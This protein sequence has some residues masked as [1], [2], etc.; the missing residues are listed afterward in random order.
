MVRGKRKSLFIVAA[1]LLG[2]FSVGFIWF[3]NGSTTPIATGPAPRPAPVDSQ[4]IAGESFESKVVHLNLNST[5]MC[6]KWGVVAPGDSKSASEA[7]RRQTRLQDWCLVVVFAKMVPSASYDPGWYEGRGNKAVVY[8]THDE[9]KTLD[10]LAVFKSIPWSYLNRKMVGYLYAIAHGA[11]VIWDF[12]DKNMLKFWIPDAAPT[13]APSLVSTVAMG[14][15]LTVQEVIGHSWPT[16]N[17][18]PAFLPPVAPSWPRGLPLDDALK[19]ECSKG[20]L[21]ETQVKSSLLAVIHSLCDRIPDADVI[22]QSTM[23]FPFYFKRTTETRPLLVPPQTL[24][25]YNA[26]AT[27]HLQPAFWAMYLPQSID[28]ELSDI[29][30]SYIAQRLF[31]ETDLRVGFTARPLVVQDHDIRFTKELTPA[32]LKASNKTKKLIMFL[33]SWKADGDTVVERIENLWSNLY[34]RNFIDH[35]DVETLH[36]WLQGLKRIKYRFPELKNQTISPPVYPT[37]STTV[38]NVPSYPSDDIVRYTA[39]RNELEDSNEVCHTSGTSL[40]FWNSDTHYGTRLDMSSYLGSLGHTVYEAVGTRQNYHPSVWKMQGIHLYDRVSNI[41]KIYYPDWTGMNSRLNEKMIKK[42]FAFYKADPTIQSVDAFYCLFPAALCEMWMPFN[43]S[44]IVMPAHRYSI[45]RCTKPEFDRL[46][47]HLRLLSS[48]EHPKHIMAAASKYDMEYLRHYTGIRDVLP[49]YAHSATIIPNN[50][51]YN[52]TRDEIIMFLCSWNPGFFWDERFVTEIKK[53]K[54]ID[55][56]KLYSNFLFSNFVQHRAAVFLPYAVMSYKITELYVLGIPLF[57]PSMKYLRNIKPIGDDRTILAQYYCAH[58]GLGLKDSDMVAHPNS[59]HPY[60][61]NL[62]ENVDKESEY[63]WLQFAD[64]FQWPHITYFDDFRDL[65]KKLEEADFDKIHKAMIEENKRREKVLLNNWCKVFNKIE[66]GR[67]TPQVYE[68]AI[69]D[70][71]G[72]TKLQVY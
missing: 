48:M 11:T 35:S 69:K 72:L 28:E 60:S 62:Q 38:W 9:V 70:L 42:N 53:F 16:F 24:S 51:V 66:K 36:L 32:Q 43:K 1:I 41:I 19:E 61:P 44:T 20:D 29:W 47:E 22:F 54:I 25:P 63:Y 58:T 18:H 27:L 40:T 8:L 6:D 21:K 2:T 12:D 13:G 26:K 39:G 52:P 17:P 71:Y 15:T 34:D 68:S 5:I 14:E 49:L 65:E 55:V 59:T 4:N 31:W 50:T 3:R 67:E 45:G 7:V 33:G 23:P 30:R 46:N 37:D 56:K 64:F 10:E 57:F